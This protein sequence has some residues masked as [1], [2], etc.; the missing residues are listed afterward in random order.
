MKKRR[1]EVITVITESTTNSIGSQEKNAGEFDEGTMTKRGRKM[2]ALGKFKRPDS[3]AQNRSHTVKKRVFSMTTERTR[4]AAR[5]KERPQRSL[6][7]AT[8]E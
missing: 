1:V 3:S 7:V 2:V 6:L 8:N 5:N 4:N